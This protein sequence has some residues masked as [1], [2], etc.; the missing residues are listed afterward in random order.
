MPLFGSRSCVLLCAIT[1]TEA[2]RFSEALGPHG[3]NI[4]HQY[5]STQ[6]HKPFF[7]PV[8]LIVSSDRTSQVGTLMLK[9][10]LSCAATCI[11][12]YHPNQVIYNGGLAKKQ[13]GAAHP[14]LLDSIHLMR[15][16]ECNQVLSWHELELWLKVIL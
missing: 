12:G 10:N 8:D 6:Q 9:W 5:G 14:P 1:L 11:H 15:L 2:Y 3:G 16:K 7:Y 13:R 4:I